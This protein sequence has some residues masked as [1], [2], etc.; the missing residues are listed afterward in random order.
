[1]SCSS[2]RRRDKLA[3]NSRREG[4][5]VLEGLYESLLTTKLQ[6]M[7]DEVTGLTSAT[8]SVDNAEQP[9]VLARHVRDAVVRALSAESSADRRREMV[10]ELLQQLGAPEDQLTVSPSCCRS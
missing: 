9:E 1:M 5:W 7:L 10:N 6:A 2:A 8:E 4:C 3:R